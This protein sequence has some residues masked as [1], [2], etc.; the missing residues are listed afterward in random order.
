MMGTLRIHI[1]TIMITAITIRTATRT[2]TAIRML[3]PSIIMETRVSILNQA[4]QA[5][6]RR[7]ARLTCISACS[8]LS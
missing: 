2:H 6:L 7:R 5:R 8:V 4:N 3:T 1:P